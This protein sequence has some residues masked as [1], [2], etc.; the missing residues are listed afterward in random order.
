MSD[1]ADFSPAVVGQPDL[2]STVTRSPSQTP[3]I[4][5]VSSAIRARANEL[6]ASHAKLGLPAGPSEG[7]EHSSAPLSPDGFKVRGRDYL[8]DRVKVNAEEPLFDLMHV[9]MWR[10]P[11]KVGNIA[12][13]SDSWLRCARAA[14]D[15]R[16]YFVVLYV[17]PATPYIHLSFFFAVQPER[18]AA[19]PHAEKLWRRFCAPGP[20]GDAFRNERWKVIPRIAEG[21]WAVQAAVGS[22]PALLGTK[23]EHTWILCSE[24]DVIAASS[25]SS[26]AAAAAAAAFPTPIGSPSSARPRGSSFMATSGPGPYLEADC[27]VSSSSMAYVLVSLIQSSC[28]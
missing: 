28:Q 27:D 15:T 21:P 22:K 14:G 7:G 6:W 19:A 2:D 20:A 25:S 4:P 24:P 13:R 17:T 26:T 18:L 8:N 12:G 5:I 10:S 1:L 3:D 11:S 16:M 9:D 23:L